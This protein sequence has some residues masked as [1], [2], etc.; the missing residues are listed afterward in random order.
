MFK[1]FLAALGLLSIAGVAGAHVTLEQAEAAAGVT[2]KITLRI[3]HGCEGQATQA[4]TLQV[5]DGFYA[6]KPMPK[7]GWVLET[8]TGPYA[9]PYDNHGTAMTEGV[10][11]IVWSQGNLDD[12]WYDEFTLR[13]TVGPDVAPGTV[14]YFPAVQTCA[15]ATAEWT[16][17]SGSAGSATPAPGLTVVAGPAASG[18]AHGHGTGHGAMQMADAA[19]TLGALTLTGPFSRATLPNAPVAG[20]FVT[21]ANTGT[22]DDRLIGAASDAAGHMEVHEMIMDGDVMKMR[23]LADGLPLPAGQTVELKPG[24]YHIMFMDLQRPLVEGETVDVTLTFEKAGQ[25]TVP[26][27][28]GARDAG[29]AM[30]G[31]HADMAK[32]P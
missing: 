18:H 5:P 9:A 2:T 14:L 17:V 20:G 24:G 7:A 32:T 4:V 11:Q 13:G 25:I 6:A 16:D 1:P 29:A 27:A 26:L 23:A 28:V 22:E 31:G 15:T 30:H 10:R 3:P 8:V 19:F 12:A 21:I